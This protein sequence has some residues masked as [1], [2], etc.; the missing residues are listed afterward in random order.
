VAAKEHREHK[1]KSLKLKIGIHVE[2][3][4]K[5]GSNFEVT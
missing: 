2:A 1:G 4:R 3:A 5:G